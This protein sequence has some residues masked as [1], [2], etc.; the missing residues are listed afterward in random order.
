MYMRKNV[1]KVKRIEAE[2]QKKFKEI[3]WSELK[4]GKKRWDESGESE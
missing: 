3:D 2:N 1:N 4:G